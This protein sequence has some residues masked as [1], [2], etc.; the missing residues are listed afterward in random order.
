MAINPTNPMYRNP[1]YTGNQRPGDIA[2]PLGNKSGIR[3]V[4][5]TPL[6]GGTKRM[7][8]QAAKR[9]RTNSASPAAKRSAK[10]LY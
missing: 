9:V 10:K 6:R 8:A 1:G 7:V 2:S 3:P 4:K 5:A